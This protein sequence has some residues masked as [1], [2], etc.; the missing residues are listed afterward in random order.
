MKNKLLSKRFQ[1]GAYATAVS[2]IVIA[3][4][5]IF[6]LMFKKLEFT[7]DLTEDRKFTL[8][9]ETITMLSE[10]EDEITFYYLIQ[11]GDSVGMFDNI[12]SQYV[13]YG[14]TI[15][16]VEKDPVSNPKFA[17]KYTDE[18][19]E[20]YS[21][22][23]VNETNGR[24]RYVP[25]SDILIEEYGI[26][27]ETYQYYSEITGL[28]MEGQLNSA[29]GYVTSEDLPTVYV[30]SG[31]GMQEPGTDVVSELEKAN[32]RVMTGEES[33]DLLATQEIP[34]DC[35]VLLITTPESDFTEE[36]VTM[37]KN[38]MDRGGKIIFSVS[39][40]NA[41]HPNLSGFMAEYGMEL[42]DGL[43]FEGDS[44]YYMQAPYLILPSAKFHE[45]TTELSNSKY[46]I[47]QYA[48]PIYLKETENENI[49]QT[50]ILTTSDS[51][52]EKKVDAQSMYKEE[53]D[54]GGS[55]NIGVHV[56]DA[57]TGAEMTVYSCY[58]MFPNAYAGNSTF[59]NID[60]LIDNINVLADAETNTV[61]V[62]TIDLASET[63]LMLTDAQSNMWGLWTVILLPLAFLSVGV[64]RVVYR[65]K[66]A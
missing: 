17:S 7:I 25:Y 16:I 9:E 6:N 30:A 61:T 36:E 66:H 8:T 19:V 33:L 11:N 15:K 20:Q 5:I 35:D 31:H 53:G 49:T 27:Y 32:F 65:K 39:Y 55:F 23:V 42:S 51:A 52:Y 37:L 63:M 50:A 4:V 12:L 3:I 54:A 47:A 43:I 2:V 44:R 60:L 21:I 14:D 22:I 40:L 10:L 34:A 64:F 45:V 56:E 26:D 13:K 48:T 41:E 1:G 29:I 24:S 46:L 58:Y 62:R 38:Y 57:A 18:N 28:D 59:A